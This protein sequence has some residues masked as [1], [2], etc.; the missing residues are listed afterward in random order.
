MKKYIKYIIIIIVTLILN[1][2]VMFNSFKI[3]NINK[4]QYGEL[5]TAK[6]FGININYYYE[7]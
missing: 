2:L 5:I 7:Y 4:S 1:T 6:M 3:T